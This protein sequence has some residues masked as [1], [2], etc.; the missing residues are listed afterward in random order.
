MHPIVGPSP[1][2]EGTNLTIGPDF[3]LSPPITDTDK[4]FDPEERAFYDYMYGTHTREA[5]PSPT[6]TPPHNIAIATQSGSNSQAAEQKTR[7]RRG[8]DLRAI[9]WLFG[10][11]SENS[12]RKRNKKMTELKRSTNR[13][14]LITHPSLNANP[15]LITHPSLNASRSSSWQLTEKGNPELRT[16]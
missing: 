15:S 10:D 4:I 13:R 14:N 2:D 1:L 9:A 16:P 12:R 3:N 7:S 5:S 11:I 8:K 6:P